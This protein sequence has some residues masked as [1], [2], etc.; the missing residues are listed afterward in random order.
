MALKIIV[1]SILLLASCIISFQDFKSRLISVWA[2][3][4]YT[5]CCIGTV[6]LFGNVYSLIS[7]S[8]STLL[9]FSF[10]FLVLFI[11]Y[12]IKERKFTNIIDSKI[13]LG[14]LLIFIAIGLTLEM[15][16]LIVFFTISFCISAIVGLFLARQ[17]KTVPLAGI[18]VWCH[19]CFII[20]FYSSL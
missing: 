13:G 4:L 14:D 7:N 15:I 5:A 17:N 11:F 6:L 19:L 1:F 9:Y 3:I 18:L 20:V 12:F 16:S 2:I 8:I 10:L